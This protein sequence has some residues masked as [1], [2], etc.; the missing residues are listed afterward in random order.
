MSI[1]HNLEILTDK[2][3]LNL[4]LAQ[5][6]SDNIDS[7]KPSHVN[8]T[9][10]SYDGK[11]F[12]PITGYL[13]QFLVDDIHLAIE[14]DFEKH[15]FFMVSTIREFF[16][17]YDSSN[18]SSSSLE[19][20]KVHTTAFLKYYG[21]DSEIVYPLYSDNPNFKLYLEDLSIS[22]KRGLSES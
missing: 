7:L 8:R 11:R 14:N 20:L 22:I 19:Q 3:K 17:D 6:L 1:S 5:T 15:K 2:Q 10:L 16:K 21:F 18:K 4:Q 13:V 12:Y 9:N